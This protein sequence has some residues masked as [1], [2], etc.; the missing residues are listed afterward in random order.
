MVQ[1]NGALTARCRAI[2][3]RL[4]ATEIQTGRTRAAASSFGQA[5]NQVRPQSSTA[6]T[7]QLT[8]TARHAQQL[9]N[10]VVA[11]SGPGFLA[12]SASGPYWTYGSFSLLAAI[13]SYLAMPETLGKT[14]ERIDA[15]FEPPKVVKWTSKMRQKTEQV[16]MDVRQRRPSRRN[17]TDEG[18]AIVFR[19]GMTRLGS[20]LAPSE[21]AV[22]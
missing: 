22:S 4:Y 11:I 14:L 18:E 8:R 10:M 12:A 19:Q 2:T 1:S 16:A 3:A 20:D 5:V 9:V 7:H 17:D 6:L 21:T 15:Q 13:I